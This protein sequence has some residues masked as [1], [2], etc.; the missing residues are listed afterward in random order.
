ME[1][2]DDRIMDMLTSFAMMHDNKEEDADAMPALIPMMGDPGDEWV[3][4]V[5]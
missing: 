5:S 2:N 3:I 4:M 1:P